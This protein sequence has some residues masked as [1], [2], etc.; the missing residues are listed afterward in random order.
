MFKPKT[1]SRS[2]WGRKLIKSESSSD[3]GE[4]FDLQSLSS[5]ANF[6]PTRTLKKDGVI[7]IFFE[8]YPPSR[9]SNGL[10]YIVGKPTV[11]WH[12]PSSCF[13]RR[14][15]QWQVF[16]SKKYR[17]LLPDNQQEIELFNDIEGAENFAQSM[18]TEE[19]KGFTTGR[20][21][22]MAPIFQ[23]I[24][25]PSFENQLGELQN[26][27]IFLKPAPCFKV[28]G[29]TPYLEMPEKYPSFAS[30]QTYNIYYYVIN[31]SYLKTTLENI[32]EPQCA[33]FMVDANR[34][35]RID[36][37]ESALNEKNPCCTIL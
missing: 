21:M 19:K 32:L 25:K 11:V 28:V 15:P 7:S 14:S 30:Y 18:F 27:T 23:V 20:S 29:E 24:I 10:F 3:E 13:F 8:E 37:N 34:I 6:S 16:D 4:G 17:Q 36:F 5:P 1:G 2:S 12:E 31:P 33:W 9:Y 22:I 26:R 35:N